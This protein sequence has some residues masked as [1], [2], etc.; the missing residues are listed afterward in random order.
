[1]SRLSCNTCHV[2]RGCPA[3]HT[4]VWPDHVPNWHSVLSLPFSLYPSVISL[5]FSFHSYSLVITFALEEADGA[6]LS[7]GH[8]DHAVA[9]R[10]GDGL[11]PG[12]HAARHAGPRAVAAADVAA[13][14]GVRRALVVLAA[15]D[16]EPRPVLQLV[17]HRGPA[18]HLHTWHTCSVTS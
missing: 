2:S 7:V 9:G 3:S 10:G 18:H 14:R 13:A 8:D 16:G 12:G 5:S 6:V 11:A 17:P 15:V 4:G 1:M